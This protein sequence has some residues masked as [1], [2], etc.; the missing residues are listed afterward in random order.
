MVE[1]LYMVET[2]GLIFFAV[3]VSDFTKQNLPP[4]SSIF[5]LYV[6]NPKKMV[7]FPEFPNI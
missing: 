5:S 7:I 3:E 6:V 1:I 4:F 2:R